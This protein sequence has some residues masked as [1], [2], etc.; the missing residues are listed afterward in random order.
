MSTP[1]WRDNGTLSTCFRHGML[2]SHYGFLF[3]VPGQVEGCRQMD[4]G[5]V[6]RQAMDSSPQVQDVAV[7]GTIGLETLEDVFAQLDRTGM[8]LGRHG[9]RRFDV[10]GTG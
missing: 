8:F 5:F 4:G 3:S 10:N 6:E 9:G 1:V 7:G 2:C